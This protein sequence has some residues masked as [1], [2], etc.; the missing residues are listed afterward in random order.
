MYVLSL[1]IETQAEIHTYMKKTYNKQPAK[2][3]LC[4][5]YMK[6]NSVRLECRL[7]VLSTMQVAFQCVDRV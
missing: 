6:Q 1:E 7:H 3:H 4:D 2:I 5:K